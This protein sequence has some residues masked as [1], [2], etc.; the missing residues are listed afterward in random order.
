MIRRIVLT[1]AEST[2]KTTLARALAAHFACP[3]V[4]EYG[5]EWSETRPG[6]PA[7]PWRTRDFVDIALEQNRR[8]NALAEAS[9]NGWLICDT[10]ALA[11]A[12]WHERYMGFSAPEVLAV[13]ARQ[14]RPFVRILA[15]D[16]I[17]FEDDGLRDGE[18][19]RHAMQAR[20]RDVL[21]ETDVPWIE[22]RG[23]VAARCAQALS[24]IA[25][26]ADARP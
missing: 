18:H 6:G 24:F 20:F 12:I 19:I 17:P 23:D 14:V 21:A 1:G 3:L 9:P 5:R 25:A 26:Q 8:E 22:V 11:T 16:E 13:A 4:L 10:D 7:A 2:G 15:G